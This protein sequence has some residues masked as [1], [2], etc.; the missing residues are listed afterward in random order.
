M[1]I[2]KAWAKLHGSYCA[3]R[4][5]QSILAMPHFTGAAARQYNHTF[6]DQGSRQH[7]WEMLKD[8]VDKKYVVTSST[9]GE[10][11]AHT[12][13]SSGEDLL[14]GHSYCLEKAFTSAIGNRGQL[15]IIQLRNPWGRDVGGNACLQG[16]S[17]DIRQACLQP[18][19]EGQGIVFVTF[20]EYM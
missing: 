10:D 2:E 9:L 7:F 20:A 6:P 8:A 5:G 13:T 4:K 18:E 12:N 1:L 19:Q 17:A 14:S 3:I 16:L 15:Q 11:E